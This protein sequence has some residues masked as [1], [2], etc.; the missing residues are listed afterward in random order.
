MNINEYV[1][2]NLE[3]NEHPQ[4]N[5]SQMM[6]NLI[7]QVDQME[8]TQPN[9]IAGG[10]QYQPHSHP[11]YQGQIQQY[12]PQPQYQG[13][14]Q[15]YQPQSQYQSQPQYQNPQAQYQ[16]PQTQYQSQPQYQPQTQPIDLQQS[17]LFEKSQ[18]IKELEI[19]SSEIVSEQKNDIIIAEIKT[20]TSG[21]NETFVVIMIYIIISN[22]YFDTLINKISLFESYP[23]AIFVFKVLLFGLLFYLVKYFL[24]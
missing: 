10:T 24:L 22:Q 1:N 12:Q 2:L 4:I 16:N 21:L 14:I 6:D 20:L 17:Q 5:G 15:Q 3:K 11:Q 19:N 9:I 18:A 7:Q 13:Q 8:Q 23:I